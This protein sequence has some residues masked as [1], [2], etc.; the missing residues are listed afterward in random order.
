MTTIDSTILDTGCTARE[1]AGT[2]RPARSGQLAI[3]TRGSVREVAEAMRSAALCST[4]RDSFAT[5]KATDLLC[6]GCREFMSAPIPEDAQVSGPVEIETT[7]DHRRLKAALDE[8]CARAAAPRPRVAGE[9]AG[10]S[11]EADPGAGDPD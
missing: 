9:D 11:G 7:G 3:E 10:R 6:D 8:F 1:I 4:C 2:P 5:V